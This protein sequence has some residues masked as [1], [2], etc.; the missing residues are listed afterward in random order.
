MKILH[1]LF[2]IIYFTVDLGRVIGFILSPIKIYFCC[3]YDM[4]TDGS[5][6]NRSC[7][8]YSY[9]SS[10][11]YAFCNHTIIFS[12]MREV[13]ASEKKLCYYDHLA[14]NRD[15]FIKASLAVDLLQGSMVNKD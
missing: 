15:V 2:C 6:F 12:V 10:L 3:L 4:F 7:H 8:T 14:L 9:P 13:P 1:R 11:S 5:V